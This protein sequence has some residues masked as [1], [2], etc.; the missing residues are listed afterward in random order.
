[1]LPPVL[2][3]PALSLLSQDWRGAVGAS[4]TA[5]IA[6][7]SDVDGAVAADFSSVCAADGEGVSA[8]AGL[9]AERKNRNING[10]LESPIL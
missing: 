3:R 6:V 10:L 2:R 5:G 1:M 9:G 8:G 4:D 7:A